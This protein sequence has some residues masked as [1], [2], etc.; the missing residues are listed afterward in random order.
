MNDIKNLP[1]K[2]RASNHNRSQNPDQGAYRT[3]HGRRSHTYRER[4]SST[5]SVNKSQKAKGSGWSFSGKRLLMLRVD[6][7]S[8]WPWLWHGNGNTPNNET[9]SPAY[10][11]EGTNSFIV[12][13]KCRC[14]EAKDSVDRPQFAPPIHIALRRTCSIRNVVRRCFETARCQ[15]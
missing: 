14:R 9:Q 6:Q 12:P 2:K 1:V 3:I 5:T 13:K 11:M 15:K 8:S 7:L 10:A 4:G